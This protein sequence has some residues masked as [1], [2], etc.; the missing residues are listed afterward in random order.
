MLPRSI[1]AV[2]LICFL[3]RGDGITKVSASCCGR[4]VGSAYCRACKTCEY[5]QHC[6]SGGSC[7][8]CSGGNGRNNIQNPINGKGI[9][10]PGTR[11]K[12]YRWAVGTRF[13]NVRIG[14]GLNYPISD[15]ILQ[16]QEVFIQSYSFPEWP[17]IIY[18]SKG[19]QRKGYVFFYNLKRRIR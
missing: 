4:C 5:C 3:L 13:S 7:G 10:Y 6:N 15:R 9:I 2:G 17:L 16:G 19:L 1:V 14:P 8:V 12:V 11:E 18:Y